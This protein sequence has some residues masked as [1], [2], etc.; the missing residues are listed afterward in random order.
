MF[1]LIRKCLNNDKIRYLIA[2]G[3]TT[4]VNLIVFY[5]LRILTTIDRNVCNVIAICMAITF[6]Y[7]VNKFFVFKSRTVGIFRTITEAVSFVGARIISMAV[8]V[9]GFAIL[10]DSFRFNE[11][12]SKLLVQLVVIVINYLLSKIFVF[13]KQR[14]GLTDNLKDNYCIYCS[15]FIVFVLVI[16]IAI[17]EKVKPFGPNSLSLV[18]SLHQYLPFFADYRDKLLNEGSLF[19]TWNIALGSNFMSLSAY[20]LSSPFNYLFLLFSKEAIPTVFTFII[21]LKLAFSA[22]GM[23][24]FLSYKD[25]DCEEKKDRNPVIIGISLAYA[26]SNYV[27]G[28]N[29]NIMWLDC[30]MIFPLIILGFKKLMSDGNPKLYVLSLFYCLYCNYYIGFIVCVFLVLWF[31]VYEH[32]NIKEF[33]VHGIRFALYSLVSGGLASFLLIPAYYGIMSTAS[34]SAKLPKWEWYGNIFNMFR[35]QLFLTSPITNQN[36][37]GNVNLYCGMFA[38]LAVFL[39]IFDKR[40][41]IRNKLG[42]LILLAI[43]MVSFNAT[44]PNFIWHGMHDQY[45]IPNRFSFLYIFILLIMTYDVLKHM[46]RI[47]TP[48]IIVAA[49]L[50][51]I[52]VALCELEAGIPNRVLIWSSVMLLIYSV[53]CAFYSAGMLKKRVFSLAFASVCVLEIIAN[54]AYGF[55]DNGYA[56]YE[57]H[58]STSEAVTAAFEKVNAMEAVG[59]NGFYRAELMDSKVLDEATWY[60]IPSVGTFCSTVLGDAVHT[61]GR[62]GFYTGANEFLYMGATPFTNSLFN[63]KY[64]FYRDGDLNNYS[65]DYMTDE[66]GIGI[67]RNPYPLS[68]GFAVSADVKQWDRDAYLPLQAQ[69]SL[70]YAM[71]GDAS[72]FDMAYPDLLVS[73]DTCTAT[74]NRQTV[75]FTPDKTGDASFMIA[76][77]ASKAGDY[78]INCRGNNIN[79]IH[80]YINGSEYAYDRYQSQIFHLGQLS[81]GDYVSV[82]YC[83]K[84]ISAEQRT[85]SLYMATFDEISYRNVYESL[86]ENQ[87]KTDSCDDGYIHG[88]I[89]VNEGQTVFTSIPYDEGWSLRV[90]GNESEYYKV[91]GAFI[92]IDLEPGTHEL[93]LVYVPR[94]LYMGMAVAAISML[95]FCLGL[96]HNTHKKH[97]DKLVKND[98]NEIDRNSNV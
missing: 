62:L 51:M 14:R 35:Q 16:I 57:E 52:F 95:I 41:G 65:F 31:L 46:R 88:S 61:M 86:C 71:T 93:E 79:K 23:A 89:A 81:E 54:A 44:T 67:Y 28:Y 87:L 2:G 43:L 58:Y 32:R 92:G 66:S 80:I 24:Y 68:I 25:V 84:N 77:S 18:D 10:C 85:A 1:G 70:A 12:I 34:A 55:G 98:N 49:M 50:S 11:L 94:G 90:D 21:A 17:A 91:C 26:L 48:Y 9:L 53:M 72:F 29:W 19:Y 30:I 22:A 40:I 83:Y 4:F 73:S 38:V 13:R 33:F 75:T 47:K 64:L 39:Y 5:S 74:V 63:I 45:G 7:F 60:S 3:C 97:A 42:N 56:D 69:N 37:D 6:A 82:E 15:F 36:F 8:E 59:N 20:Y 27:I 96:M 78:Y 76:F